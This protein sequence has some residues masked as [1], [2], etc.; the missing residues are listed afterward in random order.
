VLSV[1]PPFTDIFVPIGIGV[2][3]KAIMKTLVLVFRARGKS[4]TLSRTEQQHSK[5]ETQKCGQISHRKSLTGNGV[6]GESTMG[7]GR[8]DF[9]TLC[10]FYGRIHKIPF[11][12]FFTFALETCV[13]V[14]LREVMSPTIENNNIPWCDF[15]LSKV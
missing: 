14:V 12:Y 5:T 1:I 15:I 2:G 9:N 11:I 8:E 10:I 3:A 7:S 13:D 6:Y 4:K